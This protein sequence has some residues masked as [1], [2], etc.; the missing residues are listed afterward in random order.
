MGSSLLVTHTKKNN[1]N[2][3]MNR[4]NKRKKQK[5]NEFRKHV[6]TIERRLNDRISKAEAR[7]MLHTLIFHFDGFVP[8]QQLVSEH[9]SSKYHWGNKRTS[10][11]LRTLSDIDVIDISRSSSDNWT[12][13]I[14][15]KDFFEK[16]RERIR[17]AGSAIRERLSRYRFAFLSID[18]TR[19]GSAGA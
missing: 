14:L 9:L 15:I 1:G 19:Q 2:D 7:L 13:F 6:K 8:Q 18:R 4:K 3:T 10:R 5:L 16:C 11:V 12:L 17:R